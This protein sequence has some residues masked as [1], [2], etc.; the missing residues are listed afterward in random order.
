MI[1]P[2]DIEQMCLESDKF[3]EP[4]YDA[5]GSATGNSEIDTCLRYHLTRVS[6]CL[7]VSADFFRLL[8][9]P[10]R[11]WTMSAP[12]APSCTNPRKC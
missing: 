5:K 3:W 9:S 12:T 1:D 10:S 8:V 7:K 4:L 6:N 11:Y 2:V